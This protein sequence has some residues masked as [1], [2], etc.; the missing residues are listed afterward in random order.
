MQNE[1]VEVTL[2]VTGAFE[3]LGVPYLIAGSLAS[4]LYG[5]VRTP[6]QRPAGTRSERVFII[7]RRIS[8]PRPKSFFVQARP[9]A[10]RVSHDHFLPRSALAGCFAKTLDKRRIPALYTLKTGGTIRTGAPY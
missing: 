8:P 9:I 7:L 1:P 3:K 4:T 5:M 10:R 6:R 2:K